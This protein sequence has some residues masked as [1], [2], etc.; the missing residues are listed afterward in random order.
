MGQAD[1]RGSSVRMFW[2]GEE[3]P[4]L[5]GID[6]ITI[7]ISELQTGAEDIFWLCE[8]APVCGIA[9]I[10]TPD[11]A[12][13]DI[14]RQRVNIM[15][16]V[17]AHRGPDDQG[18]ADLP[19]GCGVLGHRRLAI[20]DLSSAGH[21][22]MSSPD[23]RYTIVFNG[24]I[25]NFRKLRDAMLREGFSFRSDSDTEVIL[26]LWAKEGSA[27]LKSLRGM[28]AFVIWDSLAREL[29]LVRD[30]FGI[31]PLYYVEGKEEFTFASEV[32]ALLK[33]GYV[34]EIDW[35]AVSGFLQLGSIPSPLTIY[36]EAQSLLPGHLLR[37]SP[38]ERRL[39]IEKYWSYAD[40]LESVPE[41]R[42]DWDTAVTRVRET[43]L[44]TIREHLVSDVP[45]GAF[46][47][48]GIDST[49]VV[50]LMRQVNH[51]RIQ[52]FSIV[53]DEADFDESRYSDL[54]ARRY[55]TE[56]RQ[57]RVGI[58]DFEQELPRILE[59]MDQ[60]T[61]DGINTY[62]V[63][64]FAAECGLKVVIS[65]LGGDEFFQ[66]YPYFATIPRMMKVLQQVPKPARQLAGKMLFSHGG[67][68][69]RKVGQVMEG[70][71]SVDRVY[72]GCRG[73]WPRRDI[74]KLFRDPIIGKALAEI[75]PEELLSERVPNC[76]VGKQITFLEVTQYMRNTLL[77]DSDV[78]SM[79]H[80]LELRVPLVYNRVASELATIPDQFLR[81]GDY[82]KKLLV[83][84]VGDLPAE[85]VHRPK[86]G[87]VFPFNIWL[88]Q[89]PARRLA[90]GLLSQHYYDQIRT[91][92][93]RGQV[94]WSRLWAIEVLDH[95]LADKGSY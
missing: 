78:F 48:G 77:R 76:E 50:S 83:E 67:D 5:S 39:R 21:Q 46:L 89:R 13:T 60:P 91:R 20:I 94:Y 71:I 23:G 41:V 95:F 64:K 47:S 62:F 53:F 57:C 30:S 7:R 12:C 24:E 56:H 8:G 29:V 66:G 86:H 3:G 42:F 69:M 59:H 17:M 55:E 85:L 35:Q 80:S 26:A 52:T 9:G 22:P 73:V 1:E 74:A 4:S 75:E 51:G 79:A 61:V 27:C 2:P 90:S 81:Q 18:V 45:V 37:Y 93:L 63:S 11:G 92:F 44:E 6:T 88:A 15:V 16:Q 54:A 43:L 70:V 40:I 14:V 87:F 84:A 49:A 65:G 68:R 33:A 72:M 58:E 32:G 82:P 10:L 25:F 36:R 31:K 38:H 28:F 19:D 34:S